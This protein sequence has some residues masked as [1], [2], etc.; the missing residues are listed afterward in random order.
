MHTVKNAFTMMRA[1]IL[2]PAVKKIM[3]AADERTDDKI[4]EALDPFP[5]LFFC[6]ALAVQAL[7]EG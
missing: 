4:V 2:P 5:A 1:V 6:V 3:Q 7:R